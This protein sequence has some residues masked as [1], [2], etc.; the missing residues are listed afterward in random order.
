MLYKSLA[1][2]M[3]SSHSWGNDYGPWVVDE[4]NEVEGSL[5]FG[6]NG[7]HCSDDI[8]W[9]QYPVLTEYIAAV[10]VDGASIVQGKTQVWQKMRVVSVKAWPPSK[11]ALVLDWAEGRAHDSWA[12]WFPTEAELYD[13][14]QYTGQFA[15][16]LSIIEPVW[17]GMFTNNETIPAHSLHR[18]KDVHKLKSEYSQVQE[19]IIRLAYALALALTAN[20]SFRGVAPWV[21]LAENINPGSWEIVRGF[22]EDHWAGLEE[23]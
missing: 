19:P 12:S 22:T 20:L 6:R 16:M 10:E 13:A 14:A 8:L 11:S 15:E 17:K 2:G 4:W 7:F 3:K 5:V 9:I 18:F 1:S 21:K 23:V